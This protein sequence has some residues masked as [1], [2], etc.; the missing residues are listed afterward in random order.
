VPE[1]RCASCWTSSAEG[2][3]FYMEELVR[4]LVDQGAIVV[5][6]RALARRC[7]SACGAQVP[8]TLTGVLQARL[9]GLPRGRERMALQQASVVGPV[10]WD[11][12]SQAL[13]ARRLGPAGAGAARAGR[14]RDAGAALEGLREYAFATTCCTR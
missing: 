10:F 7:P 8:A 3:P 2:N 9:D 11:R 13:D 6:R 4:M 14:C 5:E 12:R 1:P